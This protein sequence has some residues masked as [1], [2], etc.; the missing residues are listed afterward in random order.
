[1]ATLA[2]TVRMRSMS[3]SQHRVRMA[4]RARIWLAHI[5]ATAPRASRDRTASWMWMTA[6]QIRARMEPHVMTLWTTSAAPVHQVICLEVTVMWCC[7]AQCLV[8]YI[9]CCWY[10]AYGRCCALLRSDVLCSSCGYTYCQ[11]CQVACHLPW[12]EGLTKHEGFLKVS[13]VEGD[14]KVSCII[15]VCFTSL[16]MSVVEWVRRTV[17]EHSVFLTSVCD[18]Q[19]IFICSL[20]PL[21]SHTLFAAAGAFIISWDEFLIHILKQSVCSVTNCALCHQLCSL[22]PDVSCHQL[23]T[24]SPTVLSPA[25]HS[26]TSCALCHQLCTL[27]TSCALYH[28]LLQPHHHHQ[29]YDC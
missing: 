1:M 3:V 19:L 23:C 29:V 9:N 8:Q 16:E 6:S 12:Q 5:R 14:L 11:H 17:H 20:I 4:L 15:Y 21:I 7:A 13:S 27:V 25:V 26:V 22:S 18:E 28:Q 10:W 24:L 2:V